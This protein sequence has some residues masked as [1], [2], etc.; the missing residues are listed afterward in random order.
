MEIG[1]G[2]VSARMSQISP[3]PYRVSENGSP[4]KSFRRKFCVG[5]HSA[6]T[7]LPRC[8]V[9]NDTPARLVQRHWCDAVLTMMDSGN[10]GT[11]S[12]CSNTEVGL[13]ACWPLDTFAAAASVCGV[14]GIPLGTLRCLAFWSFAASL[15]CRAARCCW[16]TLSSLIARSN[17]RTRVRFQSPAGRGAVCCSRISRSM[18]LARSTETR[19]RKRPFV[20]L[21]SAQ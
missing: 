16:R 14:C 3:S 15:A 12:S 9:R 4:L 11:T 6:T 19:A 21:A 10:E 7:Q 2:W 18:A 13:A 17:V 20:V 1:S 8:R 5:V